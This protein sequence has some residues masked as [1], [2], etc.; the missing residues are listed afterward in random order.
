MIILESME[1]FGTGYHVNFPEPFERRKY[2]DWYDKRYNTLYRNEPS[3]SNGRK[4]LDNQYDTID[5]PVFKVASDFYNSAVLAEEPAMTSQT[6]SGTT[7]LEQ[8]KGRILRAL[9]RGTKHWSIQDYGVW[10]AE[11]N[12]IRAVEPT[13]YFRVGE[14]DQPDALVGHIIAVPWRYRTLDELNVHVQGNIPNRI[15]VIKV[16]VNEQGERFSTQQVFEFDGNVIGSALTG[17]TPSTIVS[18]CVAGTGDSWYGDVQDLAGRIITSITLIDDDINRM[19]NQPR[20]V[21]GSL[22]EKLN[23]LLTI[24][25]RTPSPQQLVKSINELIRPV[26]VI[27]GQEDDAS[28]YSTDKVIDLSGT[29]EALRTQLDLFFIGSG[30][31]PSSFGIGV[32]RGESGYARE[33]AQDAASAR[34]RAYRSD[35][36]ECLPELVVGAGAPQGGTYTF[37]WSAPPFQDRTARQQ[38]IISL[39]M[40]GIISARQAAE[41]LGWTYEL[42]EAGAEESNPQEDEQNG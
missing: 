22:R 31:P 42:A 28:A 26:V 2:N 1:E 25:E 10:T 37:N 3:I 35:L 27:D 30:L 40:A 11:P 24:N 9:R 6:T 16:G 34:A 14:P 29:F 13:F 17:L 19:R 8:N 7:W 18:V 15:T 21:P 12:M 41:A 4:L 20:F 33:K 38:E 32:G 23:E 39:K 5:L 36:T